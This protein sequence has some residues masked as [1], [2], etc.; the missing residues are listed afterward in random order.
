[1][2]AYLLDKGAVIDAIP[3]HPDLTDLN[4]ESGL[5]T[6]LCAAA[7][8]G[9]PAIVKLLLERGADVRVRDTKGRSALEL[10]EME[11]TSPVLVS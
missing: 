1:M 2:V 4:L 7:W 9:R 3:D 10:A 6:A 11:V 5:R 8:K